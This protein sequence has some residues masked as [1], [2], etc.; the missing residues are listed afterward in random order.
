MARVFLLLAILLALF[1]WLGSRVRARRAEPGPSGPAR[2]ASAPGA[3]ESM[4]QCAHC[5]VHLPRSEAIAYQG[6]HYCR[7]NHLPESSGDA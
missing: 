2:P 3:H 1:W 5:G 6:L 4:V 7:R